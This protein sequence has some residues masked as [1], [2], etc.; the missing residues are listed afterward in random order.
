LQA[1]H[2]RGPP[3]RGHRGK[4]PCAAQ[5]LA[6]HAPGRCGDG[7]RRAKRV[8]LDVQDRYRGGLSIRLGRKAVSAAHGRGGESLIRRVSQTHSSTQSLT[9]VMKAT[10]ALPRETFPDLRGWNNLFASVVVFLVALPLSMGIA[11]ASGSPPSAGLISA[12]I[13]GILVGAISGSPLQVTGPAA[14]L[15]VI[16]Y[17][18]IQRHGLA[19]FGVILALAGLLQFLAGCLRLGMWFRAVS[20][21]VIQ[22]ML[23]GIG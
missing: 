1:P 3:D 2:R 10:L 17:D 11:I 21:A 22:G 5:A 6:S 16:S 12:I 23:A 8:R 20:P 7:A 18:L 19:Q 15:V 14:G 9:T 13:G 4:R